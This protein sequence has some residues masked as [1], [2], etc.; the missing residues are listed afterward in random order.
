[1]TPRIIKPIKSI[2]AMLFVSFLMLGIVP[3][4]ALGG[5]QGGTGYKIEDD[6]KGWLLIETPFDK[7]DIGNINPGDNEEKLY[8][9][10]KLTNTGSDSMRVYIK[11]NITEESN[12][13]L[14]D[15]MELTIKDGDRIITD[16][17]LFCDA[18]D[19]GSI[20]IG[21]MAPGATKTLDFYVNLPESTGNAYQGAWM[22]VIWVFTTVYSGSSDR[23]DR[24]VS[25]NPEEPDITIEDEPIPAGPVDGENPPGPDVII[26]VDEEEVPG[27]PAMPK[28]GETS[29]LYFLAAGAI[30]AALGF[31][32][33]KK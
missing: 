17:T 32:I 5:P 28:T 22:K 15:V 29:P 4:Q 19:A 26:T 25:S 3:A 2:L 31:A 24:D 10:I 27:G 1:M 23:P 9:R 12:P 20:E 8:S 21:R 11:T 33:R 18:A 7:V 13:S 14:A 16:K 6:S 30:I